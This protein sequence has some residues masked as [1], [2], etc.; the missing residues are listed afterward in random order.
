MSTRPE[1]LAYLL[2]QLGELPGL[3]TRRMFGEYC[4]YL[5]DKPVAFVCDDLLYVKPT[6]AG[7]AL[8]VPPVWGRFYDKAKPHLL[9]SPERWD[10]REWLRALLRATAVA[11]PAPR[12]K[13]ARRAKPRAA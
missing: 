2:D 12:P 10:E 8:M 6:A 1:T 13:P 9:V 4:V 3:R 7:Q 5:D 11:L